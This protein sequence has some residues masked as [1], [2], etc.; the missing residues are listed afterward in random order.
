ME[1]AGLASAIATDDFIVSSNMVGSNIL[2]VAGPGNNG[3]DGNCYIIGID[4][5]QN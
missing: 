5:H 4:Q 1:L 3:G 2:I